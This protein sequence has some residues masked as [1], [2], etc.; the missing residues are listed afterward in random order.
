MKKYETLVFDL[1][2]T[3]IDN[4]ASIKY[5]FKY[6]V[7]GMGLEYSDEFFEEW[8]QFDNRYWREW[9][10]S[11][12][13][14]PRHIK[15]KEERIAYVRSK[16]FLLFFDRYLDLSFE[17]AKYINNIY[18][19]KL[20]VN[21]E[22]IEGARELLNYLYDN[23][24][25]VIATNGPKNAANSKIK[26]ANLYPFISKLISA[27]DVGIAKPSKEYFDY[28]CKEIKQEKDKMLLIG[29][30]LVSDVMGG[31]INKIDTCWYNPDNLPIQESI[32]PT[33]EINKL[34]ELKR[35]I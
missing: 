25:I 35:K 27:E 19:E 13:E 9:E 8:K 18:C 2:D 29:D 30:S 33:M 5:A 3:L 31:I 4:T 16:R 17:E 6:I 32:C 12:M 7:T 24:D 1:D 10:S 14:F 20:G 34:L 15:D 23:Y 11:N 28:L 26:K 21:I 22:G